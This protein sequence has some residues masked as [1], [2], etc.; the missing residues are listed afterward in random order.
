MAVT[1]SRRRTAARAATSA[2]KVGRDDHHAGARTQAP[3][4]ADQQF[5]DRGPAVRR[6]P[7]QRL[8]H[9]GQGPRRPAR[10]VGHRVTLHGGRRITTRWRHPVEP[11]RHDRRRDRDEELGPSRLGGGTGPPQ[12]PDVGED[13]DPPGGA[14]FELPDQKRGAARRRPPIDMPQGVAGTVLA[15][16][17]PPGSDRPPRVA[18]PVDPPRPPGRRSGGAGSRNSFG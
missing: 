7:G 1:G 5:A 16:T 6:N 15:N 8:E 18:G 9:G 13:R 14:G 17:R 4:L 2:R 10:G 3:A 11:L 12:H